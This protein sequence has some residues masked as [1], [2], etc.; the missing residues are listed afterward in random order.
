[1]LDMDS[2]KSPVH[3]QQAGSAYNGHFESVC[4]HPLLLFNQHGDCLAAKLRAGNV[5]S[6]EEGPAQE[7]CCQKPFAVAG[8]AQSGNIRRTEQQQ[9]KGYRG[10]Q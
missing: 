2:T 9:R 7:R 10:W 3:G 1:M 6:A 8:T 4:Y 5:S